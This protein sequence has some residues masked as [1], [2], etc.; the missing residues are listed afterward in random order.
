MDNRDAMSKTSKAVTHVLFDMDGLLLGLKITYFI[1]I[2]Y[3]IFYRSLANVSLGREAV[4]SVTSCC[5]I[6]DT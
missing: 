1:F 2:Y 5:Q 3:F 4:T 6:H